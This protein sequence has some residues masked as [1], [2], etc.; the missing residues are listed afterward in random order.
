MLI[1]DASQLRKAAANCN[2]LDLGPM[3]TC[4]LSDH[5]IPL[6]DRS[7]GMMKI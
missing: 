1:L 5:L 4:M 6:S 7:F 3:L 2:F